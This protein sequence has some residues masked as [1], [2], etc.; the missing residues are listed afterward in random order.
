MSISPTLFICCLGNPIGG[1]DGIACV[2]GRHLQNTLPAEKAE[3]I[4]DYSG[5]ALDLM[6]EICGRRKVRLIDAVTTGRMPEG[7]VRLFTEKEICGNMHPNAFHGTNLSQALIMGRKQ[8]LNLP[9]DLKLIGIEIK[10]VVSFGDK[11]SAALNGKL[12]DIRADVEAILRRDFPE[13]FG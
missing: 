9:S 12:D 1:D 6:L 7:T 2:I 13:A 10:P 11:L 8:K 4:P 3:V 5:S